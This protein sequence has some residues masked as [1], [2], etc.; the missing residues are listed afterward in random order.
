M[1]ESGKSVVSPNSPSRFGGEVHA[2]DSLVFL[3][4]MAASA[5]GR[6]LVG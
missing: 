6:A 1:A 3:G 2:R 5:G 4:E